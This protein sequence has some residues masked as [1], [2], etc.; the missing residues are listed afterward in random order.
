MNVR[1]IFG[2]SIGMSLVSC[3]VAAM[4]FM[5]GLAPHAT[6]RAFDNELGASPRLTPGVQPQHPRQ[7]ELTHP[8]SKCNINQIVDIRR[9]SLG[10][11]KGKQ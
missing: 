4:L 7:I 6:V 11:P 8:N 2:I 10:L 5:R 3:I 9:M 1:A